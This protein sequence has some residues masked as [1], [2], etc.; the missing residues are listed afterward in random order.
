M[1]LDYEGDLEPIDCWELLKKDDN[2]HLIDCRTKAEWQFVG[3]PDLTSIK[4]SVVLVEWQLYPSMAI[5]EKFYE[6]IKNA[7]LS[8]DSKLI[9]LCRS[10]EDQN[11][12][13]NF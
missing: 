1:E 7:N 12:L 13:P 2:A 8:S 4:K 9:I 6:D 10:W 5:N 3:V 11:L